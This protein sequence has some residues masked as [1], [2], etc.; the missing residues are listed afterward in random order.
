M[1]CSED[2]DDVLQT[3]AVYTQGQTIEMGAV[4]ACAASDKDTGEVLTFYYPELG[5]SN[6]RFYET[7]NADVDESN[8]DNYTKNSL[9]PEPFFNGHLGKF[10]QN[11][12]VEKW[13]IIT[14]ELDGEIKISNP[15]RTKQVSKPTVW[16]DSVTINQ[17]LTGMP[18][19]S[20]E[21]DSEGDNAIYF[22]VIS[23][24]ENNL[25]SG[26]YTFENNF[27]YYNTDNVVL[28]V[29]TN[30]PPDLILN[31][32]Y[33]FTLMDV[34]LDNWVNLVIQKSFIAE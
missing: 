7:V 33:N 31:N 26:T 12:L 3:L 24:D 29:T 2:N 5:A 28:N 13:I 30:S 14:F 1:S 4:I 17:L 20:W 18:N 19:F 6:I 11:D 25:L 22:Q 27:L 15:I 16:N 8:F 21:D 9:S 34:S 23:D 32:K 10:I